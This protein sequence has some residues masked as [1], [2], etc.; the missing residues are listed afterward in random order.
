ML[1]ECVVW[2]EVLWNVDIPLSGRLSI[3][4]K[5]SDRPPFR[6]VSFGDP[7][8]ATFESGCVITDDLSW[9]RLSSPIMFAEVPNDDPGGISLVS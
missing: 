9:T 4:S 5:V 8:D 7:C 6:L 3:V 2:V 1:D